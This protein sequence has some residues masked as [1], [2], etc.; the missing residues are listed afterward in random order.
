MILLLKGASLRHQEHRTRSAIR[1]LRYRHP[2]NCATAKEILLGRAL[3]QPCKPDKY[4]SSVF[5][6]T[7]PGIE[8]RTSNRNACALTATRHL[9][10]HV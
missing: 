10:G 6:A 2:D 4:R 9:L 5:K 1:A 3:S 8:S 7:H